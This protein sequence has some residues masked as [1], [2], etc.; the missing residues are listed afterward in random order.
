M[1]SLRESAGFKP[2]E[3]QQ[4]T[5]RGMEKREPGRDRIAR[6]SKSLARVGKAPVYRLNSFFQNL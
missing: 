6:Q 1:D 5:V 4:P 2:N 3:T